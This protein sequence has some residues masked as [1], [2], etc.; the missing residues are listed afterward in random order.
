MICPQPPCGRALSR[1]QRV[2]A[3]PHDLMEVRENKATLLFALI[4]ILICANL[5]GALYISFKALFASIG[6]YLMM[7][8]CLFALIH[9]VGRHGCCSPHI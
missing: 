7:V 9:L 2:V 5:W 3:A 4:T 8:I 6:P 1:L